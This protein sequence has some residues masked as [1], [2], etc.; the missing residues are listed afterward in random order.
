MTIWILWLD[1]TLHLRSSGNEFQLVLHPAVKFCHNQKTLG[2]C[3]HLK[4]LWK[5]S[6][7]KQWCISHT[8]YWCR[9]SS[10]VVMSWEDSH[11]DISEFRWSPV[12][13]SSVV[14]MCYCW[15]KLLF[16]PIHAIFYIQTLDTQFVSVTRLTVILTS[17]SYQFQQ[18]RLCHYS[19]A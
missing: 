12:I 19:K 1:L 4:M 9:S 17:E 18:L 13:H 2:D 7:E 8:P 15:N 11:T 3:Q 14:L 5:L 16:K 10:W 6:F